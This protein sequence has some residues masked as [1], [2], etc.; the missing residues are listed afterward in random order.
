MVIT[1]NKIY[2]KKAVAFVL[3]FVAVTV[4][5]PLLKAQS[6]GFFS[7]EVETRTGTATGACLRLATGKSCVPT[8][9]V[10]GLQVTMACLAI[11]SG[12]R[13]HQRRSC[14]FRLPV[15]FMKPRNNM[16]VNTATAG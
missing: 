8:R 15:S 9:R 13:P 7:D 14:S 1:M 4:A 5:P 16:R 6:D 2:I 12:V 3:A 10:V 11:F